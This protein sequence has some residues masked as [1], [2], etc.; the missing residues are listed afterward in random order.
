M[1]FLKYITG[2]SLVVGFLFSGATLAQPF[3]KVQQHQFILNSKP[4]Y[5]IGSNY[6]YGSY[7][8]L[9]KDRKLGTDRL[10]K[11]LNFLK[12]NGITN[13]RLLAGAE[14]T[15]RENGVE[16]VKP[17]LQPA[18]GS[19]NETALEGMDLILFEMGK[20]NMK[21]V[22]FLSN[23][24]EWSGGFMQYA[25]WNGLI[26]DSLFRRKMTWN[27]QRDF[28]SKFYTCD[29]CMNGYNEQ[30]K[31]IITR[32]NKYTKKKYYEDNTI[33]AWELA[34]E[35][36]PMRPAVNE[37]YKQWISNTAVFI[38]SIDKNHL[39]T[40]GHEG[41]M[42]TDGDLQLYQQVHADKNVDYL[43][44]HIWPKNW[45]WF[46][47]KTM[48]QDMPVVTRNTINYI[49]KHAAVAKALQKPLV[50]EEFGLPR[51]NHSFDINATTTLRDN[52]YEKVFDELKKSKDSSGVIAGVNFWA[53]GG[54]ARPVKGQTFWK[55]GDEYMGDP[56]ME[57]Q[58]LNSVFD[59]DATTWKVI[60]SF[61]NFLKN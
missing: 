26:E 33:M 1:N 42:G 5:Y 35:P 60:S 45:S 9:Q 12:A 27:A 11:E 55:N 51:D 39:I 52:Y 14:G 18:E 10:R 17:P 49:Q 20:R 4:Y 40:L 16:R 61:T 3:V 24:W 53:F 2:I 15:G 48:Q 8:G 58:G 47:E 22:I 44:I 43:T 46:R 6:W 59:S 57:E 30:A 21:A 28:T 37:A 7:L 25:Y 56:P 32:T 36:R 29:K 19:F 38:K 31:F 23:N 34:N 54:T 41:D 13:L 50:L